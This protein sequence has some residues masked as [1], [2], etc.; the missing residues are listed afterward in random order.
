MPACPSG[1]ERRVLRAKARPL[2]V[3]AGESFEPSIRE[4]VLGLRSKYPWRRN[5]LLSYQ[6]A[7]ICRVSP[8]QWNHL[9]ANATETLRLASTLVDASKDRRSRSSQSLEAGDT[10]RS[11]ASRNQGT[12]TTTTEC[13][14][15]TREYLA[16][17]RLSVSS[18]WIASGSCATGP[19][20]LHGKCQLL[21][22]L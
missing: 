12:G 10:T 7:L 3:E 14:E 20:R 19:R 17:S 13:L 18:S 21:R 16:P 5:C 2:G 1:I 9:A 15:G 22:P 4:T 8:R 11:H 6:T